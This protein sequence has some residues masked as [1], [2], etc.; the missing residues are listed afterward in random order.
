MAV[1]VA[2]N[3]NLEYTLHTAGME[4]NRPSMDFGFLFVGEF[5]YA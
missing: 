3:E 2:R 1:F 5:F 4:G